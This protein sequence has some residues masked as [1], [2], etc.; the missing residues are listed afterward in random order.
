MESIWVW[1]GILLCISQSATFSGLNIALFSLSRLRLEVAANAGDELA[2]KVL[3]LRRDANFTLATILWGNVS[4]NV[5]LTL[6]ADSVLLG[7]AAFLFSTVVITFAGEI[8]PQ[9]YFTRN[10][11]RVGAAL[12]PLLNFYKLLLWPVARPVGWMLDKLIGQ[13]PIP[14]MRENELENLLKYQAKT[15]NTE[16]SRLEARGAV[17]FLR[18]DDLHAK[19]EGE[20]LDP[21]SIISLPFNGTK[22]VF[23]EMKK[24]SKD[25]FLK[26][27]AISGKKW[28]IILDEKTGF[29]RKVINIPSFI[30]AFLLWEKPVNPLDYCHI[31]LISTDEELPLGKILESW[32]VKPDAPGD[33][34]IDED[35]ALLWTVQHKRIISGS[36]ILGRLMRKIAQ[37]VK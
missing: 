10:A 28:V 26:Q 17:N 15:A 22:P 25:P 34:V 29:P 21:L 16:L 8:F 11:L 3:A 1:L 2:A 18:L 7:L 27:L 6:L 13:E 30:N 9:A 20:E 4:I 19:E 33:D 37:E 24:S 32:E 5:L 36:D 31:P 14:W 12:S 35:I 23:P